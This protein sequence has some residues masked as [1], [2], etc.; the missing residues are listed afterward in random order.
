M[1][2]VVSNGAVG[3]S[4]EEGVGLCFAICEHLLQKKVC[5]Y[6]YCVC[7]CVCVCSVCV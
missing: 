2:A 3:T 7:V 6:I 1:L 5:V 4:S